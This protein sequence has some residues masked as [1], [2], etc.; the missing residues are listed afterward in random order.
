MSDSEV[1]LKHERI[2]EARGLDKAAEIAHGYLRP[3]CEKEHI[4]LNWLQWIARD[5]HC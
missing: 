3:F 5:K 4:P 2:A 1:L